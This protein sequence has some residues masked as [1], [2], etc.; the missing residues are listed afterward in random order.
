MKNEYNEMMTEHVEITQENNINLEV[1]DPMTL[2][3][4]QIID[5]Q[6]SL[7]R[8]NLK[9]NILYGHVFN[10]LPNETLI[11]FFRSINDYNQYFELLPIAA[12]R[13]L[14]VLTV[15]D[16]AGDNMPPNVL[17]AILDAGFSNFRIDLWRTYVGAIIKG[18]V[19]SDTFAEFEEPC[20]Y[21]Y[22][23][24]DNDFTI[25]A[26]SKAWRRGNN[27]NILINGKNVAVNLRGVNIVIYDQL[28]KTIID[29]IA[30]DSHDKGHFTFKRAKL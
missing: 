23:T 30:F 15:K 16:T 20:S 29:S 7:D 6:N 10:A 18:H 14:V 5:L 26:E 22:A 17:K 1:I 19:L 4:V 28:D 12:K 21:S 2:L 8:L 24:L 25:L 27:G 13:F 9:Y 3:Q 11:E